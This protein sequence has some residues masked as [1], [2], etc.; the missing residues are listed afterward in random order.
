[1]AQ[2]QNKRHNRITVHLSAPKFQTHPN[3]EMLTPYKDVLGTKQNMARATL[4][5]NPPIVMS[6]TFLW[7]S[8]HLFTL[9]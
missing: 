7:N 1:M 3:I 9:T 4:I 8:L 2:T 5:C 6:L